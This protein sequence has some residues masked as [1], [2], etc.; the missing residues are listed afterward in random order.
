MC[1]MMRDVST[2]TYATADA[3]SHILVSG[4]YISM[5]VNH[6]KVEILILVNPVPIHIL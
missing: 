5:G 2:L 1:P 4:I 3:F 6:N